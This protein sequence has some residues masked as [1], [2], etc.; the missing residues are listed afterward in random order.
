MT[1]VNRTANDGAWQTIVDHPAEL[2]AALEEQRRFRIEQLSELAA[3]AAA[4][5]PT[6]PDD[7]HEEV[8]DVLRA[9]AETALADIEAALRRVENGTYGT[10]ETCN[11][12]IPLERLEILPMTALCMRCARAHQQRYR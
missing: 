4:G 12:Q 3:A 6:A 9:G 11:G 10:C 5:P 7:P 1:T 2:R 8:A